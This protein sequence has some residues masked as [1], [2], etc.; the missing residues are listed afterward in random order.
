LVVGA[1]GFC[2]DTGLLSAL[3]GFA[4]WTPWHARFVSTGCAVLATWL[5]NRNF[6]FAGRGLR[7]WPLE[8]LWYVAGQAFGL[9]IN[10]GVF[11]LL[12]PILPHPGGVPIFA[13]IGAST[14]ALIANYAVA[15]YLVYARARAVAQRLP[16]A[17]HP[18]FR[19]RL[20]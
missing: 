11:G 19:D 4:D 20:G 1:V 3:T 5:L 14:A 16:S 12:L 7:H 15:N 17:S 9:A 2:V 18:E 6:T 13:Q 8:L 10:L